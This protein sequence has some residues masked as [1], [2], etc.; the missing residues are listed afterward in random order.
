MESGFMRALTTVEVVRQRWVLGLICILML[1]GVSLAGRDAVWAEPANDYT[2]CGHFET[3]TDAQAELDSG[4]LEDPSLLDWDGDGVACEEAFGLD[5]GSPPPARDYTTCGHFETKADAQEALESGLL[6]Y[7]EFLDG[8][9][10]GIACEEAFEQPARVSVTTL[11]STGIGSSDA[12]GTGIV[13]C[14]LLL[15]GL[16]VSGLAVWLRRNSRSSLRYTRSSGA[17]NNAGR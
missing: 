4:L 14:T 15:L 10:D 9:G 3:Q 12:T 7:P 16:A 11:P 1:A 2:S 8:D 6:P 17:G 5:A 13:V